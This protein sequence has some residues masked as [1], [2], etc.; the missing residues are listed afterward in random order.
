MSERRRASTIWTVWTL[1]FALSAFVAA[2][3]SASAPR[4]PKQPSA[5][6][7]VLP[8]LQRDMQG[9]AS[10]MRRSGLQQR[11]QALAGFLLSGSHA[12]LPLSIAPGECVTVAARATA[13]AH[14]VDAALYSAEGRLLVLDSEPDAHPTLQACANTNA[15][16][17]YYV[18][19]F[20]E[21]D[22]S[23]VVVPFFGSPAASHAAAAALGGRV[24]YAEVAP[25]PEV[26]EDAA[27]AFVD[28]VRKRGYVALGEPRRFHIAQSEHVRESLPV[29]PG[30]CYTVAAFGGAGVERLALHVFDARGEE[31]SMADDHN[32]KAATQFCARERARYGLE[33]VADSGSGDVRLLLYRVD[34]V[35]AGGDA[36]LWLGRRPIVDQPNSAAAKQP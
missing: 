36:G 5:A 10:V 4:R 16:R 9:L 34:V 19:Q 27:L 8:E 17:A 2:C 1:G 21:G 12:M 20:Y 18:I 32:A 6:L 22:G 35:T 3:A 26:S 23:F 25:A 15:L 33:A 29:E 7:L 31:V 24:A 13:G 28:G 14:D 11:G 30:Q